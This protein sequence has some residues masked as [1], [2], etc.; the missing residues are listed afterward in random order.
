MAIELWPAIRATRIVLE[1]LECLTDRRDG[2]VP[3]SV[4]LEREDGFVFGIVEKAA[5][6]PKVDDSVTGR[7]PAI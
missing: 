7:K 1:A 3:T 2:K 5:S 6:Q 4:K